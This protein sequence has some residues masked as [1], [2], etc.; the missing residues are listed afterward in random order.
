MIALVYTP[1]GDDVLLVASQGG[2]EAHPLWYHNLKAQPRIDIEVEGVKRTMLARE[3]GADEHARLWPVVN[4]NY[5]AF[6]SYQTKT[7]RRLPIFVCSPA[8]AAPAQ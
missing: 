4:S 2:A 8:W 3:A 6:A 5:P 7:T 1:H